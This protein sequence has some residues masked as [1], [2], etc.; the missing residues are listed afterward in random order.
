MNLAE[1]TRLFGVIIS[2]RYIQRLGIIRATDKF[3]DLYAHRA[4]R[5]HV[6]RGQRINPYGIALTANYRLILS[7]ISDDKIRILEVG[8]YHGN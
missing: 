3:A 6:L 7:I 5:L 1:A 4:L 2:Q 8:D